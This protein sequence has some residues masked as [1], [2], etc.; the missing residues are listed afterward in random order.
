MSDALDSLARAARDEAAS[1]F[2]VA[3]ARVQITDLSARF[4]WSTRHR[5]FSALDASVRSGRKITLVVDSVSGQVLRAGEAAPD[6]PLEAL[7]AMLRAS[8][9]ELPRGL[10]P[11]A[12]AEAV[13][14]IGGAPSGVVGTRALLAR[15]TAPG[16]R[17][18][19][20]AI[21]YWC[22]ANP[23][24]RALFEE[25]CDDPVVTEDGERFRLRFSLFTAQ[26]AIEA[27]EAEGDARR[28]A[29]ARGSVVAPKRTLRPPFA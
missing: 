8:A 17:G 10:A 25:H 14:F 21:E 22:G 2:G 5:V 24:L 9:I 27:W 13:R 29:A 7:D 3:A 20:P 1:A 19:P 26:G 15:E 6:A 12:L 11:L 18:G 28:V 23:S 4:P 16:E